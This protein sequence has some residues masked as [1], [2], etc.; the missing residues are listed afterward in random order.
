M[1]KAT[2]LIREGC[3]LCLERKDYMTGKK[4]K[5][6]KDSKTYMSKKKMVCQNRDMTMEEADIR[7]GE[8]EQE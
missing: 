4:L 3:L 2:L 1:K 6:E 7:A 8:E 5:S